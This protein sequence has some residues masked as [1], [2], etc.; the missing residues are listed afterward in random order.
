MVFD[1]S[2]S[3]SAVQ[4][5]DLSYI[6]LQ[7]M[8]R[9]GQI[10]KFIKTNLVTFVNLNFRKISISDFSKQNQSSI[11]KF[12]AETIY[13]K[14]SKRQI[15]NC[16]LPKQQRQTRKTKQAI[17]PNYLVEVDYRSLF[18]RKSMNIGIEKYLQ[19]EGL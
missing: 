7:G 8:E 16:S 14:Q 2:T 13:T 18:K 10:R 3:L 12:K 11:C 1:V 19:F 4:I 17:M 5:Y 15:L 9:Y 6:Y